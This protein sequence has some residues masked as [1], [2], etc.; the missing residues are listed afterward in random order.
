MVK[1]IVLLL[2]LVGCTDP[3]QKVSYKHVDI[4][5][6][7]EECKY[8]RGSSIPSNT[9]CKYTNPRG[10]GVCTMASHPMSVN[11]PCSFYEGLE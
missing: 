3:G 11:I 7:K 4:Y 6:V 2:L 10:E 8:A 5:G 9:Y 1:C